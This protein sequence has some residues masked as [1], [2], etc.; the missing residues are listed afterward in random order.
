LSAT[1]RYCSGSNGKDLKELRLV[2]VELYRQKILK[3][4][5]ECVLSC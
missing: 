4:C 1:E 5:F 3:N 2:V